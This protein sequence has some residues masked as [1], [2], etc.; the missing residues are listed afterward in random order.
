MRVVFM[1][2]PD[3][4]V[5]SLRELA[6]RFEV[7]LVLT[8]PDAVRSRGKKLEPSPVKAAALEL[9][10]PVMEATRITPEVM[11][12]L[13]EAEADIF[14]V[15]AYGCILPD[16]VLHMA[17]LGIVNVHASLLPRWRGAA[18]I[19]RAIL[20]GDERAGISIMRIGH[21]VDT[22]AYCAQ[23][24]CSVAGKTADELTVELA[25][26]GA[27]LLCNT[28]PALADETAVW[29]E[30]DESLVTHAQKIS[31]A[32]M[33]LDPQESALVNL[34]RVLASSDAAPA[35]CIAA[36][37]PVRIMRA[38]AADGDASM[39]AAGELVCQSKRIYIGCSD[40]ALEITSVKPDGKRQ[41]DASA[42]AAGLHGD[43]LAWE[44]LS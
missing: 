26:L 38:V 11:D 15:A 42:W 7:V 25:Q 35:R 10:I 2:T 27:D 34:R 40:G 31:K 39:C 36:G 5:P 21:G 8:R 1:G 41:M 29:T 12:R 13:H 3:F 32:E 4:A 24:S 28:L 17:P 9:D 37:K 20:A 23:A 43:A 16:E 18:P 14:C 33:R 30:Q 44:M 6:S 22:G 19:Q